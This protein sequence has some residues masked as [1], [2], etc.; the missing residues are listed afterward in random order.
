MPWSARPESSTMRCEH[1]SAGSQRGAPAQLVEATTTTCLSRPSGA[2]DVA[3]IDRHAPAS[4][5]GVPAPSGAK[6]RA[7]PYATNGSHVLHQ[8]FPAKPAVSPSLEGVPAPSVR[9]GP[10]SSGATAMRQ[11]FIAVGSSPGDSGERATARHQRGSIAP[12]PDCD[13]RANGVSAMLPSASPLVSGADP[14]AAPS[15]HD[16]AGHG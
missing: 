15:A 5:L 9:I 3:S 14:N 11:A 1:P 6:P 4:Q 8:A 10:G 13:V 16:A 12:E 2:P 7:R